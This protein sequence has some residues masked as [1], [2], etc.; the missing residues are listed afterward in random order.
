VAVLTLLFLVVPALDLW[1]LLVIG[2]RLGFWPTFGGTVAVAMLGGWL[3][4]REGRKVLTE[5]RRAMSELRMPEDGL[6][7]G[8]LVVVGAALLMAP[9][10]L[11]DVVGLFFLFPPTRR[12]AAK[13][14]SKY[15]AGRLAAAKRSG[16]LRVEVAVGGV[17]FRSSTPRPTDDDRLEAR[18]V[19]GG[20][21]DDGSDEAA[22]RPRELPPAR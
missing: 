8:L 14:V 7:S 3:G 4:K 13:V 6:V 11:T 18:E 5:W 20:D 1:L 15:A 22:P 19:E 10:V 16:R 2:E 21:A 12:V 17:P 9:G